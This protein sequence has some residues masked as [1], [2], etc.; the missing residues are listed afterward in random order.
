MHLS[1]LR[2]NKTVYRGV[3]N[4]FYRSNLLLINVAGMIYHL[5]RR[6]ERYC[7][8]FAAVNRIEE[9]N[10]IRNTREYQY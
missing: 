1:K 2:T 9:A 7:D 6:R 3:K 5:S 10:Y 4:C 8:L